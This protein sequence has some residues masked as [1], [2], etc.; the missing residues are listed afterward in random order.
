MN[1]MILSLINHFLQV[2]DCKRSQLPFPTRNQMQS[3]SAK[4]RCWYPSASCSAEDLEAAGCWDEFWDFFS[5]WKM[6]LLFFAKYL[7]QLIHS[8]TVSCGASRLTQVSEV[9][10]KAFQIQNQDTP[11]SLSL[12]RS[13]TKH[14]GIKSKS[15]SAA[16]DV[17]EL[18]R[19]HV[20]PKPWVFAVDFR[21]KTCELYV[22]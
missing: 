19:T 14:S 2:W 6:T 18:F 3:W 22:L 9:P 10:F 20:W 11:L 7:I 8:Y 13:S 5:S 4:E 15:C 16:W 21:E 17:V 1:T 12:S